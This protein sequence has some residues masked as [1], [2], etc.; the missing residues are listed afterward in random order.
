VSKIVTLS[1]GEQVHFF[2]KFTHKA[3]KA[4]FNAL[5]EGAVEKEYLEEGKTVREVPVVNMAKA[6]EATLVAIIE[7]IKNAEA[8][9]SPTVPWLDGLDEVD[10]DLLLKAMIELRSAGRKGKK[11]S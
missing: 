9:T 2:D 8:E 6:M 5:N 3:E 11:N 7:K 4:Y 10:Y 1:T